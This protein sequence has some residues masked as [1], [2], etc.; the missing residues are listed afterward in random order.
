MLKLQ[1]FEL[2]NKHLNDEKS[3]LLE[4]VEGKDQNLEEVIVQK[5]KVIAQQD[6]QIRKLTSNINLMHEELN[7]RAIDSQ[8]G[9]QTQPADNSSASVNQTRNKSPVTHKHSRS[10]DRRSS[11]KK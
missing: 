9:H 7:K 8:L 6:D 10:R 3:T 5:D 2:E 4:Y 11:T 1:N